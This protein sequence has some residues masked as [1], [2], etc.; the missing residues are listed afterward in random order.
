ML[1]PL[2]DVWTADPERY[3]FDYGNIVPHAGIWRARC[4][5]DRRPPVHNG[6]SR[7]SFAPL[8]PA[9]CRR[10]TELLPWGFGMTT[11]T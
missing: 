5:S 11:V 7:S 1:T 6:N 3:K 9:P 2:G 4:A 10:T 8:P